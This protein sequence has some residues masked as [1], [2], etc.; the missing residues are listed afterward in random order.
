MYVTINIEVLMENS[1]K[2][3]AKLN[4]LMEEAQL[5]LT[6]RDNFYRD[7]PSEVEVGD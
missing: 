5:I 1:Q 3:I 2:L 6:N 7:C 4:V